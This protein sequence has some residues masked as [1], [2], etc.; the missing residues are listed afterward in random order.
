MVN[1]H[2]VVVV[3]PGVGSSVLVVVVS[4]LSAPVTVVTVVL[5]VTVVHVVVP[6]EESTVQL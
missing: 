6:A 5:P 4:V 3:T 2:T 1:V